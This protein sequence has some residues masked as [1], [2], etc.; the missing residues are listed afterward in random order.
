M[1]TWRNTRVQ[2]SL[3][4]HAVR[5]NVLETGRLS[6]LSVPYERTIS[7]SEEICH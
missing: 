1:K 5:T 2:F 4:P 6:F 7:G 3:K